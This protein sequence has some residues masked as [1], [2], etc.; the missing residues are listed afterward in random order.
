[1]RIPTG[2]RTWFDDQLD[3]CV[4]MLGAGDMPANYLGDDEVWADIDVS[5]IEDGGIY[6][7]ER[8]NHRV[9][10]RADGGARYSIRDR[11]GTWHRLGTLTRA[12]V[13]F[14]I[15][16]R[17][18][19]V[20]ASASPSQIGVAGSELVFGDIF[21]G[22]DKTLR[23]FNK[24][25][26]EEFTFHQTARDALAGQGPWAN[27]L[28]GIATELDPSEMNVQW[29][30]PS[31]DINPNVAD[32]FHAEWVD[33]AVD[34]TRVFAIARSHLQHEAF[35]PFAPDVIPVRKFIGKRNG[36]WWLVELFDPIVANALP[37]GDIWHH[38]TFGSTT[39]DTYSTIITDLIVSAKGA[40]TADGTVTKISAYAKGP[41]IFGNDTPCK[42]A[43]YTHDATST[44]LQATPEKTVTPGEWPLQWNDIDYVSGPSV[45]N[46][47]DYNVAITAD[48]LGSVIYV[49][50]ST[51]GGTNKWKSEAY[52][53]FGN[54]TA[55]NVVDYGLYAT[56]TESGG[57]PPA[58]SLALIGVGV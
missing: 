26:T 49:Y 13:K 58:G 48:N 3:R 43:I 35:D 32:V 11:S 51:S 50:A 14:D 21:P 2:P 57:G 1:M 55:S 17:Q 15:G 8:G 36:V 5:W 52:V 38:G 40:P 18:W 24:Q 54:L 23:Y 9:I 4:S 39:E 22:V 20:I 12:L 37:P 41:T 33:A 34:G 16:T 10:A 47:T 6:R 7:A 27:K 42:A 46:G 53:S 31:G 19:D 56:Y 25:Y 28:L 29:R 45:T 44:L 30:D